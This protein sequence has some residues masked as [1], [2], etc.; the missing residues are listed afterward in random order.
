MAGGGWRAI[1]CVCAAQRVLTPRVPAIALLQRLRQ[2]LMMTQDALAA[3]LGLPTHHTGSPRGGIP[4]HLSGTNAS[5]GSSLFSPDS[6]A[7]LAA[8]V[9]PPPEVQPLVK[10]QSG[11]IAPLAGHGP[12]SGA[13]VDTPAAVVEWL[14]DTEGAT[15]VAHDALEVRCVSTHHA[16]KSVRSSLLVHGGARSHC[17]R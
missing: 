11:S 6:S 16:T 2:Q 17:S 9:W 12:A 15:A 4:S 3:A 14:Q 8:V 7:S 1:L 13:S 10:T 5:T